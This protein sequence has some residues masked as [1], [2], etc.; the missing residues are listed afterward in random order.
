MKKIFTKAPARK[1]KFQAMFPGT[2]IPPQPIVT[3]WGTWTEAAVYFADHFEKIKTFLNDLDSEDAKSIK[4]AKLVIRVSTLKKDLAFI[5]ANFECLV[6][7]V[8][9]LQG[10]GM[11][12]ATSLEIVESIRTSLQ[13]MRGR[14]EFLNKFDRVIARNNGFLQMKEISTI[15]SK[16][17]S[18]RQD[19]FIDMLSPEELSCF[20]YAPITSCDVERTFSKYKQVL[21]DQRRSFSFENLKMHVV[22]YC[23]SFD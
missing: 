15:L 12:L 13:S 18:T 2:A 16:G 21:G 17:K 23:N 14:T 19:N 1:H 9:K 8:T 3:R 7:G 6:T 11:P 5:K 10:K 4:K 22:I 20:L